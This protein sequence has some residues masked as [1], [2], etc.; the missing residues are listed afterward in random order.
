MPIYDSAFKDPLSVKVLSHMAYMS[1]G[2]WCVTSLNIATKWAT[3][4]AEIITQCF[5]AEACYLIQ[6]IPTPKT[7][8]F[9]GWE[10]ADTIWWRLA[11]LHFVM[12]GL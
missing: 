1:G 8:S 5:A 10:S 7:C 12:M 3:V 9:A 6:N 11:S 4:I 2:V